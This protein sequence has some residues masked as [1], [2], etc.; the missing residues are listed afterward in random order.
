[1]SVA[2]ATQARPRKS[3]GGHVPR[4]QRS[5]LDLIEHADSA[6]EVLHGKWKVHLLCSMARGIHRHGTLLNCLPGVSKK[7][8]TDTLRALE[9]DG[10]VNRRIYAEVPVRVEYSLTTLGWAL[11]APL[12]ALA[13]WGKAHG[14]EVSEARSR[15]RLADSHGAR[16]AGPVSEPSRAA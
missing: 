10:L 3:N 15:Y 7:V 6:L 11:S 13:E 16:R 4:P 12:M 14:G 2:H 8:M 1:V 5:D 9:R